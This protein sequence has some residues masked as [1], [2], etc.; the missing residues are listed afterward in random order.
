MKE[1][2]NFEFFSF[3]EKPR[4]QL[5]VELMTKNLEP[6]KKKIQSAKL[7]LYFMPI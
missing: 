3:R 5:N 1:K 2:Q 6:K 7:Q 4:S